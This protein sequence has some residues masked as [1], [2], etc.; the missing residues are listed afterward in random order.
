MRK[1]SIVDDHVIVMEGLKRLIEIEQELTVV[2]EYISY[3]EAINGLKV[4]STDILIVDILLPGISGLELIKQA[5]MLYPKLRI[6]AVSMY[7]NEPYVSEAMQNGALGYL[8]KRT[9]SAELIRAISSVCLNKKYI[10]S[11][12]LS[13]LKTVQLNESQNNLSELTEREM[14]IFKLL[15]KSISIKLI[16]TELNIQPKTVHVHKA[17]LYKKLGINT[18]QELVQLAVSQRILSLDDL[19]D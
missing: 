15:A 17:N 19:M 12:V 7:D 1:I 8:S 14:Q 11:D 13:N 6:I 5:K 4:Q 18:Q 3:E 10:S 16:A 9:A 2:G